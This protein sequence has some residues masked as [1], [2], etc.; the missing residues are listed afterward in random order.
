MKKLGL[1]LVL[2]GADC[3][4]IDAASGEFESEP[5]AF[6]NCGCVYENECDPKFSCDEAFDCKTCE[7]DADC[8]QSICGIDGVCL[9]CQAYLGEFREVRLHTAGGEDYQCQSD[10]DAPACARDSCLTY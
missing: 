7:N 4:L 2:L 10:V 3:A 6:V 5:C 1:V 9:G 8:E